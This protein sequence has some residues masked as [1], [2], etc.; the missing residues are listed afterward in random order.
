[1]L[2][3]IE[4]DPYELTGAGTAPFSGDRAAATQIVDFTPP[5]I[6][7]RHFARWAGMHAD[8]VQVLRHEPFEYRYRGP[9]HLLIV[10]ER[11]ERYDGETSV[12][13][14]PK[15]AIRSISRKLTF[16]PAGHEF[17]GW[18]TPRA[19][20]RV[21]YFYI[22][23]RAPLAD[24]ALGFARTEFK[25]LIFF[26]DRDI[27]ETAMKLRAQVETAT[28]GRRLYSEALSVVLLHELLR[29]N[30]N[31]GGTAPAPIV[32]GGLAAWQQKR[33]ADYIEE[34]L[35]DD[36]SLATLAGL[37]NLSPYHFSRAFRQSF[38]MPPHRYHLSRRIE[39][40]KSL[41]AD[42][43][44]PVTEIGLRLGFGESSAFTATFRKFTG[45]TPTDFRR[46]LR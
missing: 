15:S 16:V 43:E 30:N 23:P 2:H 28:P 21:H 12:E 25:P 10:S 22:D 34:H 6:T 40:A 7:R 42:M 26:F 37:A 41:L 35:A 19:L 38:A 39:R 11:A 14:L 3:G 45:R 24:P 29:I 17:H 27:W 46:S 9:R 5:E 20:A 36:V 18:Q 13:G 33:V 32:R 8:T 31:N 44:L 1:M 4:A